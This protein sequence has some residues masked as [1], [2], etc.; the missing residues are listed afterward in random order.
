MRG[1][2]GV[3]DLIPTDGEMEDYGRFGTQAGGDMV[4]MARSRMRVYRRVVFQ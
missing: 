2:S 3:E 4:G 1:Q